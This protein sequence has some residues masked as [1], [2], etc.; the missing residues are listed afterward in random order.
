MRI[1]I[2]TP[3]PPRSRLGNRITALRWRRILVELGHRVTIATELRDGFDVVVALHARKSADAVARATVPVVLAMTG[4]DLYRDVGSS[5]AAARSLALA[6]KIVVLHPDGGLALPRAVRSKVRVITQSAIAA[7]ARRRREFDVV[8]VGHLREEKDPFRAA[9]AVRGLED[10]N[11]RVVHVGRALDEGMRRRAEREQRE[12]PRYVWLGERS[13]AATR[14]LIASARLMVLSSIMEG[15]A[16]VLSEALVART[17]ILA[18][19]IPSSVGVLGA[20]HPGFF[21]VGDTGALTRLIRRAE[22]DPQFY[23]ALVRAGD[24]RRPLFRPA[25]ERVAWRAL[26]AEVRKL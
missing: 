4:T 18:S 12:N 16:N 23:R 11:A 24:K 13:P 10:S 3:A 5:A 17:P 1:L 19:R 22:T 8:V 2:V 15:G 26:I 6:A 14:G 25:R 20:D 21:R 9:E 7:S